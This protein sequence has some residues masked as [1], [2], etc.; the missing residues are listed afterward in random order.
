[1]LGLCLGGS[2]PVFAQTQTGNINGIVTDPNGDP[3][4]GVTVTL[5]EGSVMGSKTDVTGASGGFRFPALLPDDDYVLTFDLDGFR[6]VVREGVIVTVGQTVGLAITMQLSGVAEEITVTG[7]TPMVDT[8]SATV[9]TDFGSDLLTNIPNSR[10]FQDAVTQAPGLVSTATSGVGVGQVWSSKGGSSTSNEI[11]MDGVAVTNP[12]Y[13]SSSQ[14]LVYEAIETVQVVTG[15]LPA[16]LGNVG[17]AYINVVTKSGGNQVRGEV[18]AYYTDD[19]LQSDNLTDD[20][21]DQGITAAPEYTKYTDYS[22]NV[23]GPIRRDR[24]WFNVGYRKYDEGFA[25]N[26]FP[27]DAEF[28]RDYYLGKITFQPGV[29]HNIFVMYSSNDIETLYDP[30]NLLYSP[31]A[32][33]YRP[34]SSEVAKAKWTAILTDDLLLEVDVATARTEARLYPQ[35]DAGDSYLEFTTSRWTGGAFI[36]QENDTDRNQAKAAL[37]WFKDEMAG[38]HDFKFGLEYEKSDWDGRNFKEF[39][40]VYYH[41]TYLGYPY[42][43]TFASYPSTTYNRIEGLHLF[44]QDS[45]TVTDRVTLNLGVRYNTWEGSYPAQSR[46]A[47]T[48]GPYVNLPAVDIG[49]TTLFDWS[50]FEPR[51]AAIVALDE[52]GTSVLRA[53]LARY[54]HAMMMGYMILGNPNA[55]SASVNLWY[56]LD[57]DYFAD[58]NE[59]FDVVSLIGGGHV[60]PNTTN[61]YTD[62]ITVGYQRQLSKDFSLTLNASYREE[63]DSIDI[64][65]PDLTEDSYMAVD[66][67]DPGPDGV[68][69]TGDDQTLTVYNQIDGFTAPQ[70]IDNVDLAERTYKGVELIGTKR[71]SGKWQGL[72]SILWQQAD[73]TLG[74]DFDASKGWSSAFDDPNKLINLDGPLSL[75]R[76]WQVKL[77][78]TYVGPWGLFFSGY[79][80]YQTGTPI[81]RLLPVTLNQGAVNVVADPKDTWRNDDI[82]R[83]DLRV[84]KVFSFGA[85]PTE[86]GI[87]LDA[88]NGFNENGITSKDPRTAVGFGKAIAIQAPRVLRIG[89]R[90]RF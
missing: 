12:I 89:A 60:A 35:P 54:H 28:L 32:T 88:F 64:T 26:G 80:T 53:S 42:I 46:E 39:S 84:E 47:V 68:P 71:L 30:A 19:S 83:L 31:E 75:D 77:S 87:I 10:R 20:L 23:G 44:A 63:K 7:E 1:V 66:I 78:G 2:P 86:L 62:E 81:F 50:S 11:G 38:S 3:V 48:Y 17:G 18:A 70:V 51:L 59:V 21:R 37:S 34:D 90:V 65:K 61:P 57:A 55:L 27:N 76:E 16:E 45:W 33:W 9:A 5:S 73:G 79:W 8:T 85:R 6:R 13:H 49:D 58:P 25:V 4:P 72:F 24:V 56:D 43:A 82:T 22:F 74:T 15:G 69:G 41:L 29:S 67:T 52:D 36:Y 14:E 40:P